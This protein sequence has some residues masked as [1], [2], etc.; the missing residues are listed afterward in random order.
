MP[1]TPRQRLTFVLRVVTATTL[2]L[3]VTLPFL[4]GFGFMGFLTRTGCTGGANPAAYDMPFEDVSFLSS[5]FDQPT[6]AFFI[7]A[8]KPNGAT[9]IVVPTL[10]AWRGDR[11]HEIAVYHKNG[12]HVLTYASRNCMAN[13]PASLGYREVPQVGDAL[14]YLSAR[15]DVDGERI[16]VHGFSAGGATAILAAARYPQVRAVVAEGG[17]HDFRQQLAQDSAGIGVLGGLFRFG[18]ELSYRITTGD[19]ISVLSPIR[20]VPQIEPRPLLLV[21]GT[22]EPSLNGARQMQDSGEHVT[23]WEVPGATHGSYVFTAPDEYERVVI[24][25][26]DAAMGV[27]KP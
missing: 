22:N 18:A 17:Y 1:R 8:E 27:E 14:A 4:A 16:A 20:A 26:M 19:D 10:A 12:Y 2:V 24:G 6:P 15:E 11:I 7:P 23:L 9:V 21:Y 25:F 3:L 13:V 5:E